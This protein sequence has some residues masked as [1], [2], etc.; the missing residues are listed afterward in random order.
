MSTVPNADPAVGYRPRRGLIALFHL[1]AACPAAILSFLP[2]GTCPLCVAGNVGIDSGI[3]I[4]F[5]VSERVGAPLLALFLVITLACVGWVS[6]KRRTF[7]PYA[8]VVGGTLTIVG[9]RYIGIP[10]LAFLGAAAL[11]VGTIWCAW[12]RPLSAARSYP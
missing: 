4:P 5:V 10:A 8:L 7:A 12:A 6:S 2:T 11:A 1:I 9:A 3:G